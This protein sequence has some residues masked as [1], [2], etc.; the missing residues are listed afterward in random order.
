[1]IE[2]EL[3]R[4]PTRV[5]ADTSVAAAVQAWGYDAGHVAVAVNDTF[6]P[7]EQWPEHRLRA[8]DRVT[9]LGRIV[10]G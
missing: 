6:L 4:V 5:A 1:V 10:G 2:I 8:G 3:N 7:R 9:V